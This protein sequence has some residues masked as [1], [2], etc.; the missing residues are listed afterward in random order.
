M[1][2]EIVLCDVTVT[3]SLKPKQI[4]FMHH[5]HKSGAKLKTWSLWRNCYLHRGMKRTN[6]TPLALRREWGLRGIVEA[7]VDVYRSALTEWWFTKGPSPP[8]R[9]GDYIIVSFHFIMEQCE[10][11]TH[12][13][14]Y[15]KTQHFSYTVGCWCWLICPWLSCRLSC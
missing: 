8:N 5:A 6:D 2:F 12:P 11:G 9:W 10:L 13:L 14:G 1:K 4:I 15:I 7:E 3:R